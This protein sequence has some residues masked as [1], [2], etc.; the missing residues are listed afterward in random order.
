MPIVLRALRF[1]PLTGCC[2]RPPRPYL[3]CSAPF[4]GTWLVRTALQRTW[5]S[6]DM[7]PWKRS[8]SWSRTETSSVA[9]HR[10]RSVTTTASS[11]SYDADGWSWRANLPVRRSPGMAAELP[12]CAVCRVA[13]K[14]AENVVFRTDG[15]VQHVACPEVVCPVCSGPIRP[16]DPI[17]RD[18]EALLHGNCWMRRIRSL[19]RQDARAQERRH[20]I[21]HNRATQQRGTAWLHTRQDGWRVWRR[22]FVQ[23]LRWTDYCRSG[24]VRLRAACAPRRGTSYP[25]TRRLLRHLASRGIEATGWTT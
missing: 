2:P 8:A 7:A 19:G 14:P 18:A 24:R 6:I 13:V 12:R 5:V 10:A 25:P 23:R 16:G 21:N 11:L 17:R 3:S 20:Q 1:D 4:Q 15:R 9:R 22:P